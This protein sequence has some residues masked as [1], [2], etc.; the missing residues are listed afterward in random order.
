[1]GR[2]EAGANGAVRRLSR[3]LARGG[4]LAAVRAGARLRGRRGS[5]PAV[6]RRSALRCPLSGLAARL[7]GGAGLAP[8]GR[9]AVRSPLSAFRAGARL[10]GPCRFAEGAGG[11]GR[12]GARFR[13]SRGDPLSA[14]RAGARLRGGL[15]PFGREAIRF[16]LSA[17]RAGARLRGPCRFAEGAR[18]VV[19]RWGSLPSVARRSALRCP[20][21]GLA[22]DFARLAASRR[23]RGGGAVSERVVRSPRGP[24]MGTG[25]GGSVANGDGAA[26][27]SRWRRSRGP[28]PGSPGGALRR[29]SSPRRSCRRPRCR[30]G[31]RR[32]SR[33]RSSPSGR[34]WGRRCRAPR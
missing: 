1:M 21:S 26:T 14:F 27:R 6:A 15:A 5:L 25:T 3:G 22:L 8:C 32:T 19:V 2:R 7:P 10:R 17:F 33:S 29:G 30:S 23:A 11:W 31:A 4:L 20:L 24:G 34:R 12:A 18:G 9:E 16:P 13:W 28:P